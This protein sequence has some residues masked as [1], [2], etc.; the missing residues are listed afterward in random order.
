MLSS[1]K[2]SSN[3]TT[4]KSGQQREAGGSNL[5]AECRKLATVEGLL[6]K[7]AVSGAWVE[8]EATAWLRLQR[9]RG[10][11]CTD[12]DGHRGTVGS[13]IEAFGETGF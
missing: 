7:R 8:R 11:D 4:T 9:G 3:A 12:N 5:P 6:V 10:S 2:R 13:W 1:A